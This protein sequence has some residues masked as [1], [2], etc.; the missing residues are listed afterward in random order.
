MMFEFP[1]A[2]VNG[3]ISATKNWHAD[4]C[5]MNYNGNQGRVY[6]CAYA[7]AFQETRMDTFV[8]HKKKCPSVPSS[9]TQTALGAA[10]L[11]LFCSFY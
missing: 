6:A 3:Q 4:E 7:Y 8:R 9:L 5:T 11:I 2:V 10:V 1:E